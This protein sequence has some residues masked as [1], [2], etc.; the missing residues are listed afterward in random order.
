MILTN[1]PFDRA[2][3]AK[4]HRDQLDQGERMRRTR[5]SRGLAP[6][7]RPSTWTRFA[8]WLVGPAVLSRGAARETAALS[9]R[10]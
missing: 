10:P 5:R 7:R 6:T 9:P 8:N 3:V 2:L 4:R 1:Y